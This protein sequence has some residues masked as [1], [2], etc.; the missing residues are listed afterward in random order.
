MCYSLRNYLKSAIL[1][2]KQPNGHLISTGNS[3]LIFP[4]TIYVR[5]LYEFGKLYLITETISNKFVR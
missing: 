1:K 4:D 2:V 5:F 3:D